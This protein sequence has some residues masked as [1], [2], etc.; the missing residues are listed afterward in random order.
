M[1]IFR[2]FA[3]SLSILLRLVLM[4]PVLAVGYVA[5]SLLAVL[6]ILLLVAVSPPLAIIIATALIL[7]TGVLP[8][9]LGIRVCAE[10]FG[11]K[12]AGTFGSV[13]LTAMIYGTIEGIGIAIVGGMTYGVVYLIAPSE[14]SAVFAELMADE[15]D[16]NSEA[17]ETAVSD[18]VIANEYSLLIAMAVIGLAVV[19][20]RAALLVPMA[21]GAIGREPNG[22]LHTPFAGTGTYFPSAFI[23]TLL[24]YVPFILGIAVIPMVMG[25]LGDTNTLDDISTSIGSGDIMSLGWGPIWFYLYVIV[26]TLWFYAI[27]AAGGL[28]AHERLSNDYAPMQ[29]APPSYDK[30]IEQNAR[31]LWKDRL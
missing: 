28:L 19:A 26:L 14:V 15:S 10:G 13:T 2:S 8:I 5:I 24:S 22:Q 27:Q 17:I 29:T 9:I 23:I 6:V 4:L 21:A 7:A 30:D 12:P 18:V 11:F 31:T 3:Y 16:S 20:I 1:P 25:F